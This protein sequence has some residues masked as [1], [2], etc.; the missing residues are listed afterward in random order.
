MEHWFPHTPQSSRF[1]FTGHSF[2]FTLCGWSDW[3]FS[4]ISSIWRNTDT[5]LAI[6]VCR[7]LKGMWRLLSSDYILLFLNG[8]FLCFCL[9]YLLYNFMS[10]IDKN[11]HYKWLE[12]LHTMFLSYVSD[13]RIRR[14]KN[15]M[16]FFII[17]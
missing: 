2:L 14:Q 9:F 11:S 5:A 10:S 3:P 15:V 12:I 17:L 16:F 13:L 8:Y 6:S 4:N 7:K 1:R